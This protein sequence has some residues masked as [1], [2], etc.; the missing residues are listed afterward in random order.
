MEQEAVRPVQHVLLALTA[1]GKADHPRHRQ[2]DGLAG[3]GV[4]QPGDEPGGPDQADLPAVH[5]P[6]AAADRGQ[7]TGGTGGVPGGRH[8]AGGQ[9]GGQSLGGRQESSRH[10]Q[11][12]HGD[13]GERGSNPDW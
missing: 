4:C 13:G 7:Q 9:E 12:G 5:P 11:E 10:L 2:H 6:A 1:G 3:E 8:P